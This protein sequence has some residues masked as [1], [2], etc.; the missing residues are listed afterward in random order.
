VV[1]CLG[2]S[3]IDSIKLINRLIDI[4]IDTDTDT[5]SIDTSIDTK[6]SWTSLPTATSA[7]EENSLHKATFASGLSEVLGRELNDQAT[8]RDQSAT[9]CC[10]A[11]L[12]LIAPCAKLRKRS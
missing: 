5:D 9:R 3:L 2:G 7:A 8:M 10:L 1:A 6:V 4:D 11:I 12:V